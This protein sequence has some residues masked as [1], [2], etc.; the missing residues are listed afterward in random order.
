VNTT[1]DK[2]GRRPHYEIDGGGISL[3][4]PNSGDTLLVAL[5]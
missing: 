1:V 5:I 2:P 4:W 3:H